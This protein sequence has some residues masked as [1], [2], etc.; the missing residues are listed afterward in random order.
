MAV[1]SVRRVGYSVAKGFTTL[2]GIM[3]T[4]RV[5]RLSPS[6]ILPLRGS[7]LSAGYDLSAAHPTVV[8][9]K[10]KALVKTDLA[11]ACPENTYGRIAPRSGNL[12]YFD[13][14]IYTYRTRMEKVY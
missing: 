2:L 9:A 8:P 12:S 11:I 4:L 13:A 1:A 7:P 6:A 5:K 10:G 3:M 14:R